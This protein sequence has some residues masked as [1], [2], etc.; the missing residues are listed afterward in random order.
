MNSSPFISHCKRGL[1]LQESSTRLLRSSRRPIQLKKSELG[2][3]GLYLAGAP[4][5]GCARR[6]S[7]RR[8]PRNFGKAWSREQRCSV[9]PAGTPRE[10]GRRSGESG[11]ACNRHSLRPKRPERQRA[12]REHEAFLHERWM[13]KC[14]QHWIVDGIPPFG[15]AHDHFGYRDRLSKPSIE[16]SGR[17][18]TP[19]SGAP[20]KAGEF[21]LGHRRRGDRCASAEAGDP[22]AK[23]ELHGISEIAGACRQ[24]S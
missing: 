3:R 10:L 11:A 21:I 19:G 14:F 17:Q 23:R 1:G 13:L 8:F 18:P 6:M 4:R 2:L 9:T 15:Y 12:T 22:L 24:F 16:G 7:W 20:I 5:A